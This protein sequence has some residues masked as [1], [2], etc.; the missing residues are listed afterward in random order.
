MTKSTR[1]RLFPPVR[2]APIFSRR[3][4]RKIGIPDISTT[5]PL[6][7]GLLF[8]NLEIFAAI[9]NRFPGAVVQG[10]FI[11]SAEAG[12]IAGLRYFYSSGLPTHAARAR[13]HIFPDIPDRFLCRRARHI[14]R[15]HNGVVGVVGDRLVEVL[16]C[17]SCGPL[18]VKIPKSLFDLRVRRRSGQTNVNERRA[19]QPA[20]MNLVFILVIKDRLW[21]WRQCFSKPDSH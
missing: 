10:H 11:G 14:R 2:L 5:L 8:P 3:R 1:L 16:G 17:R 12:H 18:S 4:G 20:R 7:V 9:V 21:I 6:A 19:R 13:D 15:Q